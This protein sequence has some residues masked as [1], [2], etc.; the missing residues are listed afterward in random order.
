M[1]HCCIC[2][3]V[4]IMVE[5]ILNKH[6]LK[7]T[8]CRKF[9]LSELLK[10]DTALSES[11]IKEPFPD[12][13]DRVTFYR[14]LKT[15]EEKNVIHKIILNDNSVKYALTRHQHDNEQLHS[16]F[17]CEKCDDVL[18]LHGKTRFEADLPKNFVK[19]EVFVIIEGVCNKC[20]SPVLKG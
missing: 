3:V 5:A 11:E 20:F 2:S 14:T 18:C 12:L 8:G 6:D 13:F 15:L 1:Q 10:S 19:K 17:H 9:I 7:N 4:S 16:H